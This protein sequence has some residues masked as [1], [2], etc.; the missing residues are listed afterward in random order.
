MQRNDT[1]KWFAILLN[2]SL[3]NGRRDDVEQDTGF[4]VQ[5]VNEFTYKILRPSRGVIVY[6]TMAEFFLPVGS[7]N[8]TTV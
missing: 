2:D 5:P 6:R 3:K 4:E 8:L 1:N 7:N